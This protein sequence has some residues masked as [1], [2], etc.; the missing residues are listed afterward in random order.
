MK[1]KES[2]FCIESKKNYVKGSNYDGNRK[3]IDHL[4]EIKVKPKEKVEKKASR[5]KK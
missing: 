4:L 3:D 1:V 5:A 2:F